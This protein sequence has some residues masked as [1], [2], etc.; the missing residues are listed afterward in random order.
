[1]RYQREDR[2]LRT[3]LL[4]LAICAGLLLAV[5]GGAVA[6]SSHAVDDKSLSKDRYVA[7]GLP[8]C[9]R[10]WTGEDMAVAASRLQQLAAGHPEQ[11][12][13][14]RS[15]ESG[16]MFARMVARENL[17]SLRTRSLPLSVRLPQALQ[18]LESS[19]TILKLYLAAF[20]AKQAGGDDLIELM[21]ACLRVTQV[22]VELL[23]EFLPTL[24][25]QDP[26]YQV[27]MAGLEQVR[28]GL[29]SVVGGAITSLT[30]EQA[31]DLAARR[32]LLGYCRE[33][34]PA[35]VPKLS[36]ASQAEALG[37]LDALAAEAR[38]REL[39]PQL[40]SLRDAVRAATQARGRS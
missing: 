9:D 7:L 18:Y 36:A 38:M 32:R 31:Y 27:R 34:L 40:A 3:G 20:L 24:S 26:K 13:H 21:G 37:R 17:A 12:P 14:F 19:N 28:R 29:A 33:T 22:N 2:R 4:A 39:Q 16:E 1:M 30:E 15:H 23:D 5:G 6:A 10:D 11:L 25:P 35:I 8:S